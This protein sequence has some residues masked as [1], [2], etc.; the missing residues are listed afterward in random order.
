MGI[1][2]SK[3]ILFFLLFLSVAVSLVIAVLVSQVVVSST[4]SE[5]SYVGSEECKE[6]HDKVYATWKMTLHAQVIQDVSKNPEAIKGDFKSSDDT[7]TFKKS[8]V[9]YTH[10]MQW[11][12]RYIDKDW[13][14][15]PAQWN[16][17]TEKWAPYHE[18]KWKTIDWRKDC[19]YC[20]TTGFNKS[21]LTWEELGVGCE[22]CHGPGSIHVENRKNKTQLKQGES[23][24]IVNPAALPSL[25]AADLC[26]QCHTRGKSPDG[27]WSFPVDFKPG[28]DLSAKNFEPVPKDDEK[29]W[30]PNGTV[31]QHRQQWIEWKD[32]GH[33]KAGVGCSSCHDAHESKNKFQTKTSQNNLCLGCHPQVSTDAERGHAPVGGTLRQHSDCVGCHMSAVGKSAEV[34]DEHTH[35]FRMIAP[36]A[37]I[38]LGGGDISKQP[39]SCSVCHPNIP[40]DAL[41]QAL[42]ERLPLRSQRP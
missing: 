3:R 13:R 4:G 37:T 39:N 7:R 42:A 23:P 19:G 34:G 18:D 24:D 8:D 25:L 10:G 41:S 22:A 31:K 40:V 1:R 2:I 12:Q 5:A 6:C 9:A 35:T 27:K 11:K 32:T 20:H 16:F 17:E 38:Q 15:R 28:D 26:G 36:M 21:K 33:A 29:A 14:I 30:W